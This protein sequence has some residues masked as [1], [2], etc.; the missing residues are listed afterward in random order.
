MGY[1][2]SVEDYTRTGIESGNEAIIKATAE[3]AVK[4]DPPPVLPEQT[5]A[6]RLYD[7]KKA[8]RTALCD[9]VRSLEIS[10]LGLQDL[11]RMDE[12]KEETKTLTCRLE[13]AEAERTALC[14]SV[15][16]LE[17][18]ISLKDEVKT[19][20]NGNG[21]GDGNS[22]GH[23]DGN[24]NGHE[25]GNGKWNGNNDGNG[26]H[27]EDAGR[28]MHD[29]LRT[30]VAY[31]LTWKELIKL[32]NEVYC[33]R[34]KIQK[35]ESELWNLTMKEEDK[36]ERFIWGLPD[37]IQRNARDRKTAA[38]TTNQRG[39][40]ENLKT[41]VTF[42]ECRK[43]GHYRSDCTN[44]KKKNRGDQ[45]RNGK[46]RGRAYALGGG[47]EANQNSNVVTARALYRLAPSDM[48][49]LSAQLQE[50]LD[51]GFVRPSFSPWG[52][53]VLFVKK[54]DGSFWMCID[55]HE[56]N[57]LTVKNRYSLPRNDDLFNQV[58]GSSVYSK[59]DLRLGYH[60]LRV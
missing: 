35:M 58:Q 9:S 41:T 38:A 3:V 28:A 60:Q 46:A 23:R 36:I 1:E 31:E 13:T 19:R 48:Q 2:A 29:V 10:E 45:P 51:K 11:L 44:L 17:I 37:S 57:K 40:L 49:E 7:H 54:K 33:P 22:N 59:I 18:R 12:V 8:E 24:G 15:R 42:Y 6:E 50:L 27:N 39:P 30:N 34:N 55:Y 16:S 52:S 4:P 56:L 32:M 53:P 26:N 14:D 20:I 25:G 43:Q 5:V 21:H 47:G